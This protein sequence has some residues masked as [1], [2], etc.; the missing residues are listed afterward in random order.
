[1]RC[2]TPVALITRSFDFQLY[3]SA[4]VPHQ[5]SLQRDAWRRTPHRAI[6]H[7]EAA[8]VLG[9]FDADSLQEAVR[10]RPVAV[11]TTILGCV[12]LPDEG[13]VNDVAVVVILETRHIIRH[14]RIEVTYVHPT[15]GIRLSL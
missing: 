6:A 1:M 11:R 3:S 5:V 14:Q 10:K 7:I 13:A 15:F 12:Q 8:I 2:T 4:L 9:A